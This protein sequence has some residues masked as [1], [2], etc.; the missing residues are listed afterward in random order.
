MS[1]PADKNPGSSSQ[2]GEIHLIGSKLLAAK[3]VTE[4]QLMQ[5]LERQKTRGGR[6]GENLV[7][8]GFM[9]REDFNRF[10]RKHPDAPNTVKETGLE[11]SFLAD[12]VL[13]HILSMGEFMLADVAGSV[14]LPVSV[15]DEVVEHLQHEKL[16]EVKG[17]TQF[18]R[19]AYRFTISGQGHKRA[20]ELLEICRYTGP[21]PVP[22]DDYR[23]MILSQTI[24]NIDVHHDN[25]KKA[26]SNLVISEP[27][28][29]RLGPAVMSGKSIFMYGPPG[30]GKSSIA[31]AIA[32][33]LDETVYIPHAI[34]VGGEIISVF[35]PVSH[36][37]AQPEIKEELIDR[38]WM[39]VKRP[40]VM[41]GGELT[42]RTLDL[43]FNPISK[44]Y[45]APLQLKAN[46][47]IFIIDDFGRQQIDP[48]SLLNRWIVPLERRVDFLTLHTGMKFE[49]PFDELV[50]FCTNIEPKQLVDDAFLR[51]IR[52]K[53]LI[54]HPTEVEF[55]AIFTALCEKKGIPFDK[56]VFGFLK[57]NFYRKLGLKFNAC[58]PRDLL[59]Y[60]VDSSRYHG[61]PPQ[62]TQEGIRKAWEN[63]FVEK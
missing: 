21:A 33:A 42:L 39:F 17:A 47:G 8:L 38:R 26:F 56:G 43:E 53:I 29:N 55:E 36:I 60:L 51:R 18:L 59:D 23:K 12:L 31:E 9:T 34:L 50:V 11:L 10:L 44:F 19:S 54:D 58:E 37:P 6:L 61:H 14:K 13:K 24:K 35:D 46:N 2:G 3:L 45:L 15:V 20:A 28:L 40:V 7:A 32:N 5:A 41:V 62:L 1:A 57:E 16:I 4:A 25:L 27:M 30:N 48:K 22:L 52:Y 63:Y 49:V